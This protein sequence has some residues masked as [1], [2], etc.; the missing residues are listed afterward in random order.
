MLVDADFKGNS[1][2]WDCR[3]WSSQSASCS[4][5]NSGD[6]FLGHLKRLTKGDLDISG[7][8]ILSHVWCLI[9]YWPLKQQNYTDCSSG[10]QRSKGACSVEPNTQ[11]LPGNWGELPSTA[12]G[13]A[14]GK[15]TGSENW[16]HWL[17][18]R[19]SAMSCQVPSVYSIKRTLCFTL[20]NYMKYPLI[21]SFEKFHAVFPWSFDSKRS[22]KSSEVLTKHER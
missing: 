16:L 19:C 6:F 2:K 17:Q 10:T 22:E 7:S 12:L 1:S 9:L 15:W 5:G 20:R 18:P 8:W 4:R 3:S 11:N 13:P 21:K 14:L